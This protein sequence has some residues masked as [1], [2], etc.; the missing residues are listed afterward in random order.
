MG[1]LFNGDRISCSYTI[2]SISNM[3]QSWVLMVIFL[4]SVLMSK[5]QAYLEEYTENITISKVII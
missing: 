4:E 2:V 1:L 3:F 5:C